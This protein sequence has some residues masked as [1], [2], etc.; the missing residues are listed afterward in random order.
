MSYELRR[1]LKEL[2]V[3]YSRYCPGICLKQLRK[4]TNTSA[5]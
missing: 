1:F 5:G 3:D 2:A 4:T